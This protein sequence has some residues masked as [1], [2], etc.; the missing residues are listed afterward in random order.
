MQTLK[1]HSMDINDT[2]PYVNRRGN[3]AKATVK[4]FN[5]P[6]GTDHIWF[7][8]VDQKTSAVVK[9]PVAR[10]KELMEIGWVL[11]EPPFERYKAKPVKSKRQQKKDKENERQAI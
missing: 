9:F 1:N 3:V 11:G 6:P 8:G 2:V 4:K 5:K 7:E 10:S